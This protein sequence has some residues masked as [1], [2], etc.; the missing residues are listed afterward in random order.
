MKR[1][2]TYPYLILFSE[3]HRHCN[4]T[5]DISGIPNN[6]AIPALNGDYAPMGGDKAFFGTVDGIMASCGAGLVEGVKT[7]LD[8]FESEAAAR[9]QVKVCKVPTTPSKHLPY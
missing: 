3:I 7:Y 9:I 5:K 8:D 4:R 1:K 2:P 6:I